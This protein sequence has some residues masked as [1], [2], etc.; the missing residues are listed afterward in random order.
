MFKNQRLSNKG[1]LV[2]SSNPNWDLTHPIGSNAK[3][4]ELCSQVTKNVDGTEQIKV[5]VS[6]K[7]SDWSWEIK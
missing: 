7:V 2:F 3:C 5:M 1:K 6:I 4:I